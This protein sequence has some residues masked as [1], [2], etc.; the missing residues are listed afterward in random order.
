MRAAVTAM[1]TAAVTAALATGCRGDA[2][3]SFLPACPAG[4]PLL[5]T[6]PP[7]AESDFTGLTPLGGVS[8]PGHVFPTGHISSTSRATRRAPTARC[9]W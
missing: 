8:P 7:I 9:R 1:V 5:F 6:T 4:P 2:L 3:L